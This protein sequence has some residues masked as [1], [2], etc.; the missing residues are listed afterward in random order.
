MPPHPTFYVKRK[1]YETFGGFDTHYKIAAD[2]DTILRFLGKN[3]CT[4]HYIPHVL[5]KM[6]VGG[7]SNRS[8]KNILLKTQEDWHALQNN[9][10]GSFKTLLFKNLS[11]APQFFKRDKNK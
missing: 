3:S 1:I 11:K 10:I 4:T 5:V 2:Y 9:N 8:L 6:R 7:V